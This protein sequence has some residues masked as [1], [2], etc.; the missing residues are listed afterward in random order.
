[1]LI[2]TLSS[3]AYMCDSALQMRSETTGRIMAT[4]AEKNDELTLLDGDDYVVYPDVDRDEDVV[5]AYHAINDK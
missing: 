5:Y 4:E 2:L 1:M 3:V